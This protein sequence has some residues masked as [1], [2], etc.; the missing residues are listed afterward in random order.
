MD[1][2]RLKCQQGHVSYS[3]M[4][5]S[6]S[7]LFF[8]YPMQNIFFYINKKKCKI[9]LFKLLKNEDKLFFEAIFQKVFFKKQIIQCVYNLIDLSS[10]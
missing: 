10:T 9:R 4:S 7:F 2:F 3:H 5:N 8:P 1:T 6:T